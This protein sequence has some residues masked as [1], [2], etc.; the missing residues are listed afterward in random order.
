MLNTRRCPF[1]GCN[2][3]IDSDFYACRHCWPKLSDDDRFLLMQA[4]SD[5]K[6]GKMHVTELV[7][8]QALIQLKNTPEAVPGA[9]LSSPVADIDFVKQVKE[10]IGLRKQYSKI[11]DGFVEQKKALG[12]KLTVLE[13][14]IDKKA[15]S[16]LHPEQNQL[17]L[18]DGEDKPRGLPDA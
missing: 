16:I 17:S 6:A 3:M 2:K 13:S 9:R 14:K 10:Y 18:F 5:Y 12:M 7:E 1:Y 4:W 11:K 8:Y 15:H